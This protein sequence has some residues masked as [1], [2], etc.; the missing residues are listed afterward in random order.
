M[1]QTPHRRGR[2]GRAVRANGGG[3]PAPALDTASAPPIG[4]NRPPED[5][6]RRLPRDGCCARC[7]HWNPPSERDQADYRAFA[8]GI[9]KR[10]VK[11]PSGSCDRVLLNPTG[12]TAFAGTVARTCCF[13][14]EERSTPIDAGPRRGFVTIYEGDR[15]VWQGTEGDEP[16]EYRQGEFDL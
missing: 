11:E 2:A 15:I 8:L 1:R 6:P 4:H 12:R 14:F 5:A 13:N 10:R 7:E 16:A 9:S 3:D